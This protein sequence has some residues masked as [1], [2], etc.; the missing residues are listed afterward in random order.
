MARQ[1]FLFIGTYLFYKKK[2]NEG[3]V[4]V[5]VEIDDVFD[6]F[7]VESDDKVCRS[8]KSDIKGGS[9]F[10]CSENGCCTHLNSKGPEVKIF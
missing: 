6:D 5:E 3:F 10:S 8:K 9:E 1:F 7:K 4:D 2:Q